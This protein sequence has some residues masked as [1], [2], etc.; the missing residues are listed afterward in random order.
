MN[1]GRRRHPVEIQIESRVSDGM[2]GWQTGWATIGTEWASIDSIS[3]K[4]F[5]AAAAMQN[6]TTARI[7]IAYRDNLTTANR[8]VY[9]GKKYD[10]KALLPNNTMTELAC[11]CEVGLI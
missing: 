5:V 10:I 7:T 1:I 4:E 8:F 6:V 11:M 3:G 2:G 9:H